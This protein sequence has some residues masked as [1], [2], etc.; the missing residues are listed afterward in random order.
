M[1]LKTELNISFTKKRYVAVIETHDKIRPF[2]EKIILL[3][4]LEVPKMMGL[5]YST[6]KYMQD[7]E[8]L[9]TSIGEYVYA[10]NI[11]SNLICTGAIGQMVK[12]QGDALK[13]QLH[14]MLL[15]EKDVQKS[16]EINRLLGY[17]E[18]RQ[19]WRPV[20]GVIP[21]DMRLATTAFSMFA[22]YM[23]VL[24]QLTHVVD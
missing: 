20:A 12:A 5:I 14:S 23:I 13:F 7:G 16:E 24:V 19:L 22:T 3:E 17:I 10:C 9:F 6:L 21:V 11:I 1:L 18:A 4:L 15:D 2:Y 8:D